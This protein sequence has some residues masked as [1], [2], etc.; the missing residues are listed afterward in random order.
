MKSKVLIIAPHPDDE[1][2]G[3]GGT[4]IK[5]TTSGH[6]VHVLYLSSGDSIERVRE[7]EAVKVCKFLGVTSFHFLRLKGVNFRISPQNT[8]KLISIL[9]ATSPDIVFINHADDAD[10]EHRIAYQ[11]VTEC[12]WRYNLQLP[13]QN[14]IKALILYEVHKPMQTYNLVEDI[15]KEMGKKITALALYK[16]QIQNSRLDIA[17]QG[18]NQ[19]RGIIHEGME[20]AEVFQIKRLNGLLSNFK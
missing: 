18:L 12:Y 9:K 4:I 17:I 2:L 1:L 5:F 7:R 14:R 13:T 16:S 6:S 3:C 20:Y 19:Y 15:S 8:R 11:L 10:A